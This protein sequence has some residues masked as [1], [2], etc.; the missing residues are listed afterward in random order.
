[1]ASETLSKIIRHC[2]RVIISVQFQPDQSYRLFST[3]LYLC[4]DGGLLV[5]KQ[6]VQWKIFRLQPKRILSISTIKHW[7]CEN[8]FNATNT[9]WRP[10]AVFEDISGYY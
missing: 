2:R 3:L 1:M 8:I 9:Y 5:S 6:L 7:D 4:R 10:G